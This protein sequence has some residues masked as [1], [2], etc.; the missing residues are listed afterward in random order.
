MAMGAP[1]EVF[2]G[3]PDR[4]LAAVDEATLREVHAKIGGQERPTAGW[5]EVRPDAAD[6]VGGQVR[7]FQG[8]N[9]AG[10]DSGG[11]RSGPGRILRSIRRAGG[12]PGRTGHVL[13]SR[14]V[15]HPG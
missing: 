6:P 10:L 13:R 4:R 8:Q 11:L 1:G 2:A 14:G 12:H 15:A 9:V 5:T 3:K 7:R